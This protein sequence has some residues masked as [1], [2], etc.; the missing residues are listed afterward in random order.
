MAAAFAH[1][2]WWSVGGHPDR[3]HPDPV[4]AQPR[5][6]AGAG[7]R[8]HRHGYAARTPESRYGRPVPTAASGGPES[9]GRC[10]TE[11]TVD[12]RPA[13]RLADTLAAAGFVAAEEE[14]RELVDAA[15][16]D[17]A[18]LRDARGSGA[19]P[20]EP[21]AWITGRASFDDL[22]VHVDPGRLRPPLAERR[23]GPA[24]RR[25]APR[26]A[27]PPSTCA[28]GRAPSP[29][30]CG[31]ATP[32]ARVVATDIDRRAVA[33]ARANGVEAY[34]GDLFAPVPAELEGRTDVVVAV[35]PYVPTPELAPPPPRHARPSRT[36]PTTTAGPTAP[37]SCAGSSTERAPLPAPRRRAAARAGRRPGRRCSAPLMERL[38][39]VSVRD[40]GRRGRRPAGPARRPG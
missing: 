19:W 30:P 22:D 25:P 2:F 37:R 38:G 18:A 36:P 17:A 9:P 15:G 39:Y 26:Q 29:W 16:G 3:L 23:A 13:V 20:G 14:A 10:S 35:V 27:A 32:G 4:P 5:R 12:P 31:D 1:T 33:C 40:L 11:R 28:P 6:R 21:L 34:A 24:R 7:R 8:E